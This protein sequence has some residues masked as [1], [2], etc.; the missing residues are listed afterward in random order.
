MATRADFRRI[1]LLMPSSNTTQ[2]PEFIRMMPPGVTLHVA[3]L[4]LRNVE[5]SATIRI[6]EDIE[7]E[8]RKLADADV[9]AIV[10]A[11]TAPSSRMGIGYD[12]ELIGRIESASGKPATTASTASIQALATLGARRLT[13]AA[14]WSNEVNAIAAAFIEASAYQVLAHKALGYVDNLEIG[15]LDEQ[16]ALDL[17]QEV[18]RPDADVLMLACGNWRTLGIVDRLE[19]AIG[20]PVLTTN[21][22]SLWSVLRLAGHTAPVPGCG[23]LMRDFMNA[24]LIEKAA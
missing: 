17:G 4:P 15:L 8:A 16:T 10:L 12:R 2:E 11:A 13:I 5:P 9:D 18:D 21:Q 3:R 20:K 1:G 22:V 23:V 6:V 24:P 19:A 14:P 7:S